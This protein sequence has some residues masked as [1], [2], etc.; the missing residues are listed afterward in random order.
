MNILIVDA[1]ARASGKRYSTFDVVGAGPR[2]VAGL[3]DSLGHNVLLKTYE[4]IIDN[5]SLIMDSDILM[6]SIM[7][8]D[9]GAFNKLV[10]LARKTLGFTGLIIAGGPG[11]FSYEDIFKNVK[12]VDYVLIGE[13]EIPLI[14]IF[15]SEKLID[16]LIKHD[17]EELKIVPALAYKINDKIIVTSRHIHTDKELLSR[18]K[19]WIKIDKSYPNHII[20]RYYVEVVRG[21]SNFHRPLIAGYKG[22][23]CMKCMLCYHENLSLRLNCPANIPPGCGFC[24]VP[25]Q[26]GSPRSRLPKSVIEEINGLIK[27][28][29]RRIV[30]SGPDFLDYMR[31]EL[32]Y[33]K[34]LTDPCSP[35]PNIERIEELLSGIFE[36]ESVQRG[37]VIVSIENI[38][39][40]LVNEEVAR[41]MGKYL[42][43]TTIHIGLE[44]GDYEFNKLIGKPIGP[45]HVYRAVKLL[46]ENGLRP[47]VYLM[48]GL[49]FMREKTY[50]RTISAIRK[51]RRLGVEKI[52]LYKFTP[53]PHTAFQYLK[54]RTAGYE[55]L[56]TRLKKLVEKVNI[57]SKRK[58][59][60]RDLLVYL[61]ENKG[62]IYGYPIRHGPVVFIEKTRKKFGS[63]T[64][65][66]GRITI[67]KI[68]PR[69]VRGI[70]E[71]VIEC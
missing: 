1:L 17:Y 6:I 35:P 2:V 28:G 65:C 43:G 66:L 56:I 25:Y 54:P 48:Y 3:L 8:S 42:K 40:C 64:G 15:S 7:T 52:T 5:P 60:G 51:L 12:G 27:H 38:K 41:I 36:L 22:L 59:L 11:S 34:P 71:D 20:Y 23:N 9:I 33:P 50:L 70:L 49:P 30:L 58:L 55:H 69:Y 19:P 4:V 62:K 16:S 10:H 68:A 13:A 44:T 61:V 26:F 47:Y 21:C 45:E 31:E 14:K 63:I 29:A 53:L 57:E 67:S 32:V 37:R 39:A 24:S 18:I 46:K